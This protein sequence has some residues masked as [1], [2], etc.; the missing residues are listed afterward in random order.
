MDSVDPAAGPPLICSMHVQGLGRGYGVVPPKAVPPKAVPPKA[1]PSKA[2]PAQGSPAQGH[3][4]QGHPTQGCH[5]YQTYLSA[6]SQ[7]LDPLTG[8]NVTPPPS[9][10]L[11][12]FQVFLEIL[13]IDPQFDPLCLQPPQNTRGFDGQRASRRIQDH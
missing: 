6:K 4:T 11:Q 12:G 10:L 2:G 9:P 3:P 7:G 1:V 5:A 8:S 13:G